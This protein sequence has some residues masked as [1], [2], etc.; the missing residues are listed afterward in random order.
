MIDYLLTN[1]IFKVSSVGSS[2]R[3]V[4]HVNLKNPQYHH[5]LNTEQNV[6]NTLNEQYILS[7]NVFN[8]KYREWLVM[9]SIRFVLTSSE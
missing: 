7:E 5:F 6:A 1:P 8:N 2:Q 4:Q 3:S 9:S